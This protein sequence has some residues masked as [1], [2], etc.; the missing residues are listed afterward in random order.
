MKRVCMFVWNHFTNDARVL[1]ECTTLSEN[2]YNVHLFCID[3][4]ADETLPKREKV[5]D[6]FTVIRLQRYPTS[7]MFFRKIMREGSRKKWPFALM[8]LAIGFLLGTNFIYGLVP[9]L[10][11]LALLNRRITTLFIRLA[12]ILRMIHRGYKGNYDMYHA[13]DLNTLPQAYFCAKWRLRKKFL[14]YDSHE[15]QTSRTGYDNRFYFMLENFLVKRVD[16]MIVENTT[17]ATFNEKL[18][19]FYP[20]VLHN[21]PSLRIQRVGEQVDLH[22]QLNIPAEE[23]ILLYQGGIQTGRGLDKLIAAFPMFVEGTLLFIGDGKIKDELIATVKRAGLGEKV[24]FLEKVPLID[25]PKYTRSAYLGFQVLNNV[26]YNH[27]SASSN[28][29][30][31]YMMGGVPVVAC[32]FPEI[33]KVVETEQIGLTVDP[34]N[35]EEIAEAVNVL[36]TDKEKHA[37]F[38]S[39][40]YEAVKR[41]NWEHEQQHLLKVYELF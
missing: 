22:T 31:E 11:G 32:N 13:N 28:K 5:N 41:Y 1:R 21:Y 30:F 9:L 35:P 23:K 18:Y 8:F 34:H 20:H 37:T 15:V 27:W 25:L 29:L 19:G 14:I 10:L 3:N 24:R 4:P 36:L 40:C 26:C 38:K 7:L 2:G 16:A 39:N 33:K 12:L 17:R 6:C